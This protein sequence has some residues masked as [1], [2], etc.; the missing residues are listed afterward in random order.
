MIE[1]FYRHRVDNVKIEKMKV[2]KISGIE[3]NLSDLTSNDVATWET[4]WLYINDPKR[5]KW[6]YNV[7]GHDIVYQKFENKLKAK[8]TVLEKEYK[9]EEIIKQKREQQEKIRKQKQEKKE[10]QAL[11]PAL[12]ELKILCDEKNVALLS[13]EAEIHP[14]W[15]RI[16]SENELT[17]NELQYF[18]NVDV[19]DGNWI[20][21]CDRRIWQAAIYYNYFI[22][23][24]NAKEYFSIKYVDDWLNYTAKCKVPRCAEIVG[25][26][27]KRYPMLMTEEVSNNLPSSWRT[28]RAY[29]NH[30]CD[31][32]MLEYSGKE[33]RH[34][35]SCWYQVISQTPDTA[36]V[37][38]QKVGVETLLHAR[39]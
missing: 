30:L 34:K 29:F 26:Y 13:Q 24:K 15:R 19:P 31:L 6:L 4:F 3:I 27:G 8:I 25:K 37:V 21:G 28:L 7:K 20:Y 5:V 9:Q 33:S 32:G 36:Q 12:E 39:D 23:R 35:G 2:A 11:L 10:K 18:L 17:L 16:S 38:E 22:S 1:I 14:T